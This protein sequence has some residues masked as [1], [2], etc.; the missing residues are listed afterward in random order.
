LTFSET[1]TEDSQLKEAVRKLENSLKKLEKE[2]EKRKYEVLKKVKE[3]NSS[4][5]DQQIKKANELTTAKGNL[6]SDPF[7]IHVFKNFS[8]NMEEIITMSSELRQNIPSTL[9]KSKRIES[10]WKKKGNEGI[11]EQLL[12]GEDPKNVYRNKRKEEEE[13]EL[14]APVAKKQ[15]LPSSGIPSPKW[16]STGVKK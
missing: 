1:E 9:E 8:Q 5:F 14:V 10:L 11:L 13:K 7:D 4:E 16:K 6:I 3:R 12:S 15:A 2:L